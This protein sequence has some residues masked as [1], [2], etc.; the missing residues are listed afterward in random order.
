[1]FAIFT[2]RK[3]ELTDRINRIQVELMN[4]RDQL[5][6]LAMFGAN[7]QD[8][9]IT[10]E[11]LMCSPA[12][13]FMHQLGF[14]NAA[15]RSALPMANMN[16]HMYLRNQAGLQ[17]GGI[18]NEMPVNHNLV[19]NALLRQQLE[20]QGKAMEKRIAAEERKIEQKKLRLEA[21]E[22]AA[23]AELEKVEKAEEEGIRRSAPNYV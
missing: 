16:M 11:E 2:M 13:I 6:D 18:V 15:I 20:R 3:M 10:P 12:S 23:S 22:K 8:G 19:F 7:A 17:A 9:M 4:L 5:T 21:Q 14:G 1:M